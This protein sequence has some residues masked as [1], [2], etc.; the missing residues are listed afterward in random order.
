MLTHMHGA[1]CLVPCAA[2]AATMRVAIAT[3]Q[4]WLAVNNR[5]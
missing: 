4:V 2:D 1:A 3:L 5:R